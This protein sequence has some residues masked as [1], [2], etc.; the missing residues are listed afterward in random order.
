M[1]ASAK[2]KIAVPTT[3]T[4]RLNAVRRRL[5]KTLRNAVFV[6]MGSS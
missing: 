5:R 6:S 1:Y 3:M 4:V 2:R